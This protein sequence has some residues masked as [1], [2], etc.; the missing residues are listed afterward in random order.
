MYES[1]WGEGPRMRHA[2]TYGPPRYIMTNRKYY[3]KA[4]VALSGPSMIGGTGS[5]SFSVNF[6][7]KNA[8][9]TWLYDT[10]LLTLVSSSA[11]GIVVKPKTS[12]TT[13]DATITA[14]FINS[15]GSVQYQ[16]SC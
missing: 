14:Q 9:L 12:T 1:K 10:N 8:T 5:G 11:T 16:A 7:V 3:A 13:G 2:P 6:L 4:P 15:S